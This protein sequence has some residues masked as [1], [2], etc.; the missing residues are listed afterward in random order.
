MHSLIREAAGV[1]IVNTAN[2]DSD[3]SAITSSAANSEENLHFQNSQSENNVS[4]EYS[5]SDK[6]NGSLGN[7]ESDFDPDAIQ[8]SYR[9]CRRN[10]ALIA[11][12]SFCILAYARNKYANLFQMVTGYFSFAHNMSKKGTKVYHK[13]GLVVSYETVRRALNA[14]GQAVLRMLCERVNVEQFFLSYD[15]MNFYEKV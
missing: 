8:K 14:N 5:S 11:T 7:D 15:N 10:K 13:M 9:D 1:E 2:C 12:M 4:D 3:I 6:S